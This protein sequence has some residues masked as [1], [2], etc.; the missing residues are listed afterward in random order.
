M[1]QINRT[2]VDQM[3]EQNKNGQNGSTDPYLNQT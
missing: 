3:D 1:D 2:E